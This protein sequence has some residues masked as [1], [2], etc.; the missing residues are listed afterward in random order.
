MNKKQQYNEA[1]E[2]IINADV[3]NNG[4]HIVLV[5]ADDYLPA[6]AYTIGLFQTY[7]HPEIICF[8]L[9]PET[10]KTLTSDAHKLVKQGKKLIPGYLFPEFLK[11]YQTQFLRVNPA[12]YPNYFSLAQQFYKSRNFPALQLVWP[13]KQHKFPWENS[14]DPNYK[15]RQPL[16]DRNA[17]FKFLEERDTRLLLPGRCW[18]ASQFRT[19][20][21]MSTA[22][23][24]S[25][26]ILNHMPKTPELFAWKT[27]PNLIHWLTIFIPYLLAGTPG[28]SPVQING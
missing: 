3:E 28:A 27:L 7:H 21:I 19:F 18:K 25:C 17:D 1:I 14:F 26:R 13:D 24:S 16:L 10:L 11:G 5:E 23:G 6:F 22:T 9:S 15:F 12:Y 8:G 2:S 4:C 20:F